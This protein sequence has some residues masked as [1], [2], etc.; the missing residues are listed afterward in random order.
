MLLWFWA[1]CGFVCIFFQR[2]NASA[3]VFLNSNA[4]LSRLCTDVT[5][6]SGKMTSPLPIFSWGRGDVCTQARLELFDDCKS[7]TRPGLVLQVSRSQSCTSN[8]KR[9]LRALGCSKDNFPILLMTLA[10]TDHLG[11]STVGCWAS[12]NGRTNK[13]IIR[14]RDWFMAFHFCFQR[15]CFYKVVSGLVSFR[16]VQ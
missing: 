13:P 2:K 16:K 4:G 3:V 8:Q 9:R 15:F 11:W 1:P 14:H 5:P 6:P 7:R 12:R 10:V